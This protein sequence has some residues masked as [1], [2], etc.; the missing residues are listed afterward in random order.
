MIS[1]V[2]STGAMIIQSGTNRIEG[3]AQAIARQAISNP[4]TGAPPSQ[5]V[6]QPL[7][8]QRLALYEV[9][10][11]SRVIQTANHLLGS[12]LDAFA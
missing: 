9:Q 4:V 6:I 5:E 2:L 7:I 11:G 12:L 3:S 1:D 8:E 10:A